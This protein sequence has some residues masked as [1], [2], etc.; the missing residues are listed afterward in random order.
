MKK[1]QGEIERM[2]YLTILLAV[3]LSV[4]L[5]T[6]EEATSKLDEI[7]VTASRVG[8]KLSDTSVTISVI[9]EKEI[10]QV[11]YRNPDEIL[12]RI[13]GIYSHDFGGESALTSIRVPTHFTN[14][15]TLFLIDGVPMSSYGSGSSG[16]FVEL[17]SDNIARVEV[18][19]GPTSA[20]YGSNA[21]GGV[22]N[23]ITKNP[24]SQPMV[25]AWTELGENNQWRSSISGSGSSDKLGFNFGLNDI[26]SDNWRE[27][28]NVDKKAANAKLQYTPTEQGLFTFKLDYIYF[29]NESPGTLNEDDFKDDWKQ[30]YQTFAYTKYEKFSPLLSYTHYLNKGEINTTFVYRDT[31]EKSIPNYAIRK[32]GPVKY[33]GQY[34][35]SDT[36]DFD[37]QVIY[38]RELDLLSSRIIIGADAERGKTDSKQYN[39]DVTFD[40]ASNKYTSYTNVGIDDDFE[41]TT[42]M[43]APYL[44][45]EISPVEDLKLTFGGRYDS[46]VYD[47]DSKVDA[48]KSGDK[49]FSRFSPKFGG[50][51]HFHQ[52]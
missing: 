52:R 4:N 15:Y 21:I 48:S 44:Q 49:D 3:L 34:S 51:Y 31:D 46:V 1:R 42:K 41:I 23:V 19:R 35:K 2:Q 11:K 40:S 45:F 17:N 37:G 6:A 10:E 29:D 24:S 14:P 16:N 43:Y 26:N 20:S 22:I 5:A 18:V 33:V 30:S 7:V 38:T 50:V 32:Q 27:H 8:E 36:N 28:A 39:L 9:D 25:K 13:P 12:R 47:V